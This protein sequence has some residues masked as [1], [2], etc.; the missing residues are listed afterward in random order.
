MDPEQINELKSA[1]VRNW[2]I[3][4]RDDEAI[5]NE[6][7]LFEAMQGRI[8]QLLRGDMQKRLTAIYWLDISEKKFEAAMALPGMDKVARALART[9]L[10]RESQ[11]H[12][13]RRQY[14]DEEKFLEE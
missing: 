4:V 12:Q 2:R 13:S 8:A 9:V 7:Q 10:E 1:L 11:R 6:D 14:R 5:L 3:R